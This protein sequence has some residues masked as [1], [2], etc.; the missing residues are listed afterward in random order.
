MVLMCLFP[1]EI[2]L[3][4]HHG[5]KLAEYPSKQITYCGMCTDDK[6]FLGLVTSRLEPEVGSESSSCH[7][8]MAESMKNPEETAR[9]ARAFQIEGTEEEF[10]LTA[11]PIMRKV[12]RLYANQGDAARSSS[13]SSNGD[14][15]ISFKDDKAA[16]AQVVAEDLEHSFNTKALD[17][18][19]DPNSLRMSMHKYLL[20]KQQVPSSFSSEDAQEPYLKSAKATL[21]PNAKYE[22]Q[23]RSLEDVRNEVESGPILNDGYRQNSVISHYS[24]E[25][26]L[27]EDQKSVEEYLTGGPRIRKPLLIPDGISI[28]GMNIINYT[29]YDY[30]CL[31]VVV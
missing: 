13:S 10:P 23:A 16:Q 4:N 19:N 3:I 18:Q 27:A 15:G 7:V 28:K 21:G 22:N 11:E 26:N 12:M 9:R 2:M 25:T 24:S 29:T 6:R 8:F 14:S 17:T 30:S 1:E 31:H 20:E 5:L